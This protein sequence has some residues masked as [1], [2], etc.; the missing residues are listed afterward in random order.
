MERGKRTRRLGKFK[1]IFPVQK[2]QVNRVKLKKMFDEIRKI[3]SLKKKAN[4]NL[5]MLAIGWNYFVQM[6]KKTYSPIRRR[7]AAEIRF[8]FR[9]TA[10][11][12]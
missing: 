5:L 1:E 10:P 3:V 4:V 8:C 9:L 7:I 12:R 2:S 6:R 11:P